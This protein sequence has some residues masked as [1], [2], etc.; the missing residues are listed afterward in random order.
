[1]TESGFGAPVTYDS[2]AA[3]M[4]EIAWLSFFLEEAGDEGV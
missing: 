4:D 2:G 1:V 3:E